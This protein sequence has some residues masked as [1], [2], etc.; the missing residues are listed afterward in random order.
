MKDYSF[1]APEFVEPITNVTVATGRDT[2]LE[3][4]VTNIGNYKSGES[5]LGQSYI[6]LIQLTMSLGPTIYIAMACNLRVAWLKVDSLDEHSLSSESTLLTIH[7]QTVIKDQ[8]F[9][10]SHNNYRQWY[11][12]IKSVRAVDKGWYMCQI[13]TEPMITQAGYVDVL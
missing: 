11:L 3:C 2:V 7:T 10:V 12:H 1:E 6:S 4:T 5:D 9:R 13:N 8:R